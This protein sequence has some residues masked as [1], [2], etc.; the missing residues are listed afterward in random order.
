MKK[1]FF[2]TAFLLSINLFAQK[3][4]YELRT[5]ELFQSSS[6][7]SFNQYFEKAFIPALNK[8][9]IKK[10]KMKLIKSTEKKEQ[11]VV[12]EEE[13]KNISKKNDIT[14]NKTKLNVT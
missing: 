13:I 6:V 2:I 3:E 12:K 14:N 4:F 11:V 7:N 9:G 5:Y 1:I 10:D 8:L